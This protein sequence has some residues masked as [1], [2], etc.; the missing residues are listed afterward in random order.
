LINS[1]DEAIATVRRLSELGPVIDG[2]PELFPN[3]IEILSLIGQQ[4]GH[5]ERLS[6]Q[7]TRCVLP[8][9]RRGEEDQP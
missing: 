2:N 5:L 8:R 9:P 1:A 6:E 3:V 7:L 4:A